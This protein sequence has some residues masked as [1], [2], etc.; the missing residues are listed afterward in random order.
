MRNHIELGAL[1]RL[2]DEQPTDAERSHLGAC[3]E[4]AS[5]L[6]AMRRDRERL[7]L[8]VVAPAPPWSSIEG[9][10]VNSGAL[11]VNQRRLR[12]R[13]SSPAIAAGLVLFAGGAAVGAS[14][15]KLADRESRPRPQSVA[16]AA[17]PPLG[18]EDA[19]ARLELLD[20]IV[21]TGRTM[22][23]QAPADPLVNGYY[24]VAREERDRLVAGLLRSSS[25]SWF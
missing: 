1:A 3:A 18:A 19:R 4:C 23:E 25:R 16:S 14:A 13:V 2:L 22:L 24:L 12:W 21:T 6:D 9:V 17:M 8:P 5:T 7:R 20:Q 15:V 10:L 11:P